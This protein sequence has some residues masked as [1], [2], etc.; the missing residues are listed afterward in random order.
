[1]D[2]FCHL[3]I[4]AINDEERTVEGFASTEDID[5]IN[6]VVLAS[7]FKSTLKDFMT[8][9]VLTL[10][11][12]IHNI[13]GHIME[14]K[15]I[16]GKGLFVK[17]FI[18]ST[19]EVLWTKIKEKSLRAFSFGFKTKKWHTEEKDVNGAKVEIRI[20][21][22]LE[23]LEI[24][25]VSIP[26]NKMALFSAVKG[27]E[28]GRSIDIECEGG[29]KSCG[30]CLDNYKNYMVTELKSWEGLEL[31]NVVPHKVYP[32]APIDMRWSFTAA[33]G[34]A[35]LGDPDNPNWAR[36]KTVHTFF[37]PENQESRAGFKLP[38]HKMIDGSLKT[39]WRGV[40]AAFTA[41]RGGRT[42]LTGVPASEIPRIQAHLQ[43]HAAEFD[44][45]L[46]GK[47]FWQT[48]LKLSTEDN[49][50]DYIKVVK[51]GIE[52]EP[53]ANDGSEKYKQELLLRANNVI[54]D[55]ENKI[56]SE[57]DDEV[58]FRIK[59]PEVFKENSFRQIVVKDE[60]PRVFGI[61]G[62]LK[63]EKDTALQSLRFPK[64]EAWDL[65]KA[66]AWVRENPDIRKQFEQDA[67]NIHIIGFIQP[68]EIV[69]SYKYNSDN[70]S[71][72]YIVIDNENPDNGSTVRMFQAIINDNSITL[73]ESES[74]YQDTEKAGRSLSRKNKK[75]LNGIIGN[76][77]S[78]I[79][80]LR[81]FITE[82]DIE[83]P[84]PDKSDTEIESKETESNTQE[85]NETKNDQEKADEVV[86]EDISYL[87]EPQINV[88][89][90]SSE[91][92]KELLGNNN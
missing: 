23:L 20:I 78:A 36:Y 76:L 48:E 82:F 3:E 44:R 40:V 59:D 19:E 75:R 74:T 38:H 5:R 90:L 45:T 79:I 84:K 85:T 17:A 67:K 57:T 50:I 10:M 6:D 55:I 8:N 2:H 41:T 14:A 62:R 51:E 83:V 37:D 11:H 27:W 53:T 61:V 24:A 65:I 66:K 29:C 52:T 56:W 54:K 21:E 72:D 22:D 32:L 12:N 70:D 87:F 25:L 64:K 13:P 43:K 33:D 47:E 46:G 30:N 68:N 35:I 39:V 91:E 58:K 26:M 71:H 86:T 15:I 60:K 28:N 81:G 80:E 31:K 18:D 1:M 73:S 63:G 9:P 49:D 89:E 69:L 88:T 7:A 16:Q 92:F 77:D 42:P 4:K 34:N